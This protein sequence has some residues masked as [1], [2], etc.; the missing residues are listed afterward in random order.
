MS[1]T[2]PEAPLDLSMF[3]DPKPE[4]PVTQAVA[5]AE[6]AAVADPR[7]QPE[8]EPPR[9]VEIGKL[10]PEDLAAAEQS[11]A[12]VDFRVTTSSARPWR[13][14]PGE[15]R[16]ILSATADRGAPGGRRRGW[17]ALPPPSSTA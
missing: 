7:L 15:N 4:S 10:S 14:S 3:D 13:R 9:L 6:P 5:I 17:G 12:R 16:P 11:A 1:E 8:P 2:R